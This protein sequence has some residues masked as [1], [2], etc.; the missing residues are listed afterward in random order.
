MKDF[1]TFIEQLT[2]IFG[3][4]V[5][6]LAIVMTI[7]LGAMAIKCPTSPKSSNS[8]AANICNRFLFL[9]P[10]KGEGIVL[11]ILAVGNMVLSSL[12]AFHTMHAICRV[13]PVPPFW[14]QSFCMV[15]SYILAF[16]AFSAIVFLPYAG[17]KSLK[18]NRG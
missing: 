2:P 5:F 15:S 8:V 9:N 6:I 4:V 1:I 18:G 16:V 14:Q 17:W 13:R 11:S 7:A 10:T 3:L 12:Y